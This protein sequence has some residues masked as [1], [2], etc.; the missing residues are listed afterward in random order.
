MDVLTISG[1]RQ[2]AKTTLGG[3]FVADPFRCEAGRGSQVLCVER[4]G[5]K[6]LQVWG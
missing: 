4:I 6:T 3:V 5:A 2:V 1:A